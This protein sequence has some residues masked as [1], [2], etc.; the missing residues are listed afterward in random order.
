[1]CQPADWKREVV[2]DH[3]FDFIDTRDYHDNSFGTRI[4]YFWLYILI[5]K[6]FLVYV[7][8]IYTGVTMASS[9]NWSN[10]IFANCKFGEGNCFII[11]FSVGKWLFI[12]SIIFSFLLLAYEAR[13]AKKIIAS[14]DI[15]FAFTNPMA[16]SYYSLRSYDHFCFFCNIENSTKKTDDF[17]FFIFFTFKEWKRLLLA[18]GP[19]AVINGMTLASFV[20]AKLKANAAS[21]TPLNPFDL[22]LYFGEDVAK[23]ATTNLM[24]GTMIFT[25]LIFA[26]S[27]ILLIAAGILYVP[28][29]C[30]IQGNLKEYCVHKVDKRIDELVKRKHK[31][32][33]AKQN[34]LARKEAAGDF[35]HKKDGMGDGLPQP[36][37]PNLSVDDDDDKSI[38]PLRA[39]MAPSLHYA[40]SINTDYY[41]KSEYGGDYPPMPGYDQYP[42]HTGEYHNDP[43][44]NE[45]LH[46][47]PA[48]SQQGYNMGQ[49][50]QGGYIADPRDVYTGGDQY[51]G[52]GH[53]GAAIP[54]HGTPG[55]EAQ[56]GARRRS[57]G[58]AYDDEPEPAPVPQRYGTPVQPPSRQ[59]TP[60]YGYQPPPPRLGTP[61]YGQ[62]PSRQGTPGYGQPPPRQGTP[63]QQ[64]WH[65]QQPGY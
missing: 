5:L 56:D 28:L 57:S 52:Y 11:P 1:M 2:P 20:L 9:D 27:L 45:Y 64:G 54:R 18:D 47:S 63:A 6:T 30:Y 38:R 42:P 36:T 46:Q 21:K 26:G 65:G 50:Q 4:K 7:A 31:Q 58:L 49:H 15:S 61:G 48:Y 14:R 55:V 41:D 44:A 37:L 29:L 23:E 62:P 39:P 22:S 10:V 25:V 12:G 51:N 13:K 32:R 34:A 8:D 16:N 35:S 3:K 19:R 59:G 53:P 60:G 17:A 33:M 24:L 40:S 43:Y